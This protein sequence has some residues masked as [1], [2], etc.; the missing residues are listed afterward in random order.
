M[1]TRRER[2]IL[3]LQDDLSSGMVK[4]AAATKLLD[5]QLGRLS[6]RSVTT[7]R[8]SGTASRD[9]DK[10]ATSSARAGREVDRLSGRMRIF[11]DAAAV[12][13]PSLA[14]IGAIAIPAVTGLASQLGFA[15][16]GMGA[17]VAAT[18]GVGDALKAVNEAALEPTAANLEKA[19]KAMDLLGPDAQRFV[20]RFQEIRP[21]LKDIRDSAAAGWFP[22]LTESLDSLQ[23]VGPEVGALFEKIGSVGGNLVAEGAA[24][25]AG[26]GWTDFRSFVATE[27]PQALDDLGRTLGN[28]AKGLA[29]L[30]MAFGPLNRSFSTWLLDASRGFADWAD[31]L[32]QTEGFAEFV[33]Y[34]RTNGPRVADAL[35]A[36]GN[37][38]LE[39]IEAIA[40]LGGPSLK[41]LETLAEVIGAIADS[42]IGTPILAGVAA[43]AL[44][45]RTLQVTAA[46]QTRLTGSQSIGAALAGGGVLG[47][48][49]TGARGARSS[50]SILR[51]DIATIG[52]TWATAGAQSERATARMNAAMGR[53]RTTLAPIAKGTALVGGL[54][55]AT[56]GAADS[57]GLANTASLA[58]MGTIAGPWGA[59]IGGGI[60]LMMDFTAAANASKKSFDDTIAA[61]HA[62]VAAGD[63]ASAEDYLAS[64]GKQRSD[65]LPEKASVDNPKRPGY[66]LSS[67][68]PRTNSEI[69][70]AGKA[71]ADLRNELAAA[72]LAEIGFSA[73]LIA[74]AEEAGVNA[75]SLLESVAAMNARTAAANGAFSAE[76]QWRNALKA[77][78]EQA[79]KNNAGIK[80][81]S[82]AALAN[83]T[84]LE[85]LSAAW[86]RQR[87]AMV[88]ASKSPDEVARKY[89]NA[90]RAFIDTAVA[91][92][93]P[94]ARARELAKALLVIPEKKA[95]RI[96]VS[97]DG[98]AAAEAAIGRLTRPRL[99]QITTSTNANI[100]E[101][102]ANQKKKAAGGLVTGPGGPTDD[103][104]PALLSNR[105]YVIRA[106]AVQRYGVGFFDAAN[107]ERLA[108]GGQPGGGGS[109][110]GQDFLAYPMG[111]PSL[112]AWIKELEKSR[113]A[114]KDETDARTSLA[115]QLGETASGRFMSDL[116]GDTDVWSQGGGLAGAIATLTGDTAGANAYSANIDRLKGLG[117]DD[118]GA[119]QAL[120]SQADAATVANIAATATPELVAQYETASQIRAGATANVAAQVQATQISAMTAQQ[121]ATNAKLD[122]LNAQ[123]KDLNGAQKDEARAA[124]KGRAQG[125]HSVRRG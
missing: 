74:S 82:E 99:V 49:R 88:E 115:Q 15:A 50:L 65:Y 106:S 1:A 97:V 29:E 117:L 101:A 21:V 46:L 43:L 20:T 33:D 60:G 109:R 61:V 111:V 123:I 83:R 125:R 42:N 93:V 80:G 122:Q 27:A 68:V 56:S 8:A 28:V 12:F 22:G 13:G 31:G 34:I 16:V 91:M 71:V 17:L 63:L 45:N 116:F 92:G 54:A 79:A 55:L 110:R 14:P 95:T 44:Y 7:S 119:L 85:G 53:T 77:A 81:N 121:A 25:F 70:K 37:A 90:K 19:R 26:P 48:T 100:A 86:A 32:S 6:T 72:Q 124:K 11:A 89:Q 51:A 41:I 57:F 104:I 118:P 47:A 78:T 76:T 64:A 3:E 105:E 87:D 30:W 94:I 103:L 39:I 5:Q 38:A 59:A 2:V 67:E 102:K 40:P 107:A 52:S 35:L 10:I 58:M 69:D 66:G 108:S 24:A 9:I 98:L 114:L 96:A 4:A 73:G 120:L 18:R 75:S 113:D 84:A 23:Q 36:I 62:A 112:E